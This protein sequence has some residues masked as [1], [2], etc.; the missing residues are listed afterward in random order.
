MRKNEK[1]ERLRGFVAA[2]VLVAPF[3][4][5]C[6]NSPHTEL[7]W[8]GYNTHLVRNQHATYRTHPGERPEPRPVRYESPTPRPQNHPSPG[9]DAQTASSDSVRFAWPV[10][11]HVISTFGSTGDGQRNDGINIASELGAPIRA[12][13]DGTVT[14]AGDQLRNY[15]NLVLIEHDGG[16]ITAYAHA[17][18]IS[19]SRGDRVHKGDVIGTVGESGDVPRPQVH[20]EIRRGSRPIDPALML[21]SS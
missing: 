1:L 9:Y 12:S 10:N 7:D 17:Q 19:V 6:A 11:G 5:A 14:Y 8:P 21:A 18:S 15:G 13:A 2:L 4:A 3:L 20:F 16:F